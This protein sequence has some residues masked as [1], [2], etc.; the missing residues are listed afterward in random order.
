MS[1]A[2]ELTLEVIAPGVVGTNQDFRAAL[3]FNTDTRTTVPAHIDQGI[4]LILGAAHDDHRLI[5]QIEQEPITHLRNLA[6]VAGVQPGIHEDPLDIPL[7]DIR[8]PIKFLRNR[9]PLGLIR[10]QLDYILF[11][12]LRF[13][14]F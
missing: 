3:V 4:D 2:S 10:G 11:I 6:L 1:R 8:V 12:H 9:K 7:V 5:R 14:V 13:P